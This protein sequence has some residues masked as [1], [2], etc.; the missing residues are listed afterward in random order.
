MISRSSTFLNNPPLAVSTSLWKPLNQPIETI[1]LR[2]YVTFLY[3][4]VLTAKKI[5]MLTCQ[6]C[7]PTNFRSAEAEPSPRIK[8]S[9]WAKKKLARYFFIDGVLQQGPSSIFYSKQRL[10][11]YWLGRCGCHKKEKVMTARQAVFSF[12]VAAKG[13]I[14]ELYS[15]R[16][17][18]FTW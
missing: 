7:S 15:F 8:V 18:S 14:S 2:M 11:T 3:S 6:F 10:F 12:V 9:H 13:G 17:L 1:W 4:I 16:N 5:N